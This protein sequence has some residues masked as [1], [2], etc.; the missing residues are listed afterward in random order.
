MPNHHRR[1]ALVLGV[2][3]SIAACG[4]S[5]EDTSTT[6]PRVESTVTT[7]SQSPT[8]GEPDPP[9]TTTS[10]P[11]ET[12][13]TVAPGFGVVVGQFGA[14]GWWDGSTWVQAQDKLP[15]DGTG[16][17][18]VHR[19][20]SESYEVQGSG[21]ID[22]CQLGDP[23]AGV[24]LDPDPWEGFPDPFSARPL[25]V[26]APWDTSPH[27]FE[28]FEAGDA[29]RQAAVDLLAS[30]GVDDPDPQ[31]VQLFRTDIDSDGVKEV[32][33][34]IE[35]RSDPSGTLIPAAPGDYSIAFVRVVVDVEVQTAVLA[36]W[37]VAE[38]DDSFQDL[39][40]YRFDAFFDADGDGTDEVALGLAYYEGAAVSVWDWQ[41]PDLGFVS[42]IS[43]GCG[44]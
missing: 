19:I 27:P 42:V 10:T 13:T 34:V 21:L 20:G 8:T 15:I 30:R 16:P 9:A 22:G 4:G 35:R 14:L 37:I 12:T 38:T 44:A 33:A 26:S 25:A 3:V 23:V 24:S 39:V 11:E 18:R 43:S 41:G 7:S 6:A 31:F 32:F 36:E 29:H 40:V 1:L 17:F 2:V 5:A 28:T